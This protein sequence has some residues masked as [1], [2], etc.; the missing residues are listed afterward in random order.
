[1]KLVRER[2]CNEAADRECLCQ[3]QAAVQYEISCCT[4]WLR[5]LDVHDMFS[6]PWTRM[7]AMMPGYFSQSFLMR[8]PQLESA[9]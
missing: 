5:N 4:F 3:V 2:P 6:A 1:M 9:N 7:Q 8:V